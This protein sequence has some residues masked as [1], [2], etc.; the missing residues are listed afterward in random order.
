MV[1]PPTGMIGR[2][3]GATVGIG[4]EEAAG[5]GLARMTVSPSVVAVKSTGFGESD[6]TADGLCF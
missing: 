3:A 5:D 1:L 6:G 4:L 2:P